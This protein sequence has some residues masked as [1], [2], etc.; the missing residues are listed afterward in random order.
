MHRIHSFLSCVALAACVFAVRTA[1]RAQGPHGER[2]RARLAVRRDGRLVTTLGQ[3]DF[4]IR[5]DGKPQPI[6]LFDNT[7]Q[8][9]RLVVMLD[10]SGSMAGNLSLLREAATVSSS[11]AAPDDDRG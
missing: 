9:I 8:P 3:N 6:T 2:R 11:E 7:P 5:D 1:E 4:E 10:V